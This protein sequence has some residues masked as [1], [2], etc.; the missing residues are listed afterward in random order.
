[1]KTCKACGQAKAFNEFYKHPK[2]ADG[3]LGICKGC[4]KSAVWLNRRKNIDR[5]REYDRARSTKPHR[6]DL[7]SSGSKAYRER[8][9][10]RYAA[11]NAVSNALRD[12]RLFKLPCWTCGSSHVEAHHPDYSHPLD[13]I[14][15]CAVHHKEIHLAYPDDHYHSKKHD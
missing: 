15:L 3:L 2:S 8:H 14:W 10:E 6:L 4:H 1:M 7:N 5:I 13:V 11:N 9:P 12:G